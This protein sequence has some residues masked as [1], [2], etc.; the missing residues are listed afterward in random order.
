[1]LCTVVDV[2][3][4]SITKHTYLCIL[5]QVKKNKYKGVEAQSE[6]GKILL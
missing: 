4:C 3:L 6:I 5:K 2:S 1:M